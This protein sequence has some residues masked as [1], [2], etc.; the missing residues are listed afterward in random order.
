M[1]ITMGVVLVGMVAVVIYG[2]WL[3]H[4]QDKS[5][6]AERERLNRIMQASQPPSAPGFPHRKVGR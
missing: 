3:T 5:E 1:L 6:D 4:E 2:L